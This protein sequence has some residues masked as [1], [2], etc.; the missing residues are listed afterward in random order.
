MA[1]IKKE[2]LSFVKGAVRLDE[3]MSPH[4]AFKIGGPAEAWVSP[5]DE[6]DLLNVLRYAGE[7][8]IDTFIIGGGSKLLV[9]DKGIRGI[10]LSLEAPAFGALVFEDQALTAGC[11]IKTRELMKKAAEKDLGGLE[12]LAGIPGT[13]GGAL[14]MNAGWPTKAI[15]DLVEEVTAVKDLKKIKL[16][17]SDLKFSYR[18][19]NLKGIVLLSARLRLEKKAKDEAEAEINKNFEKKRKTQDLG[20]PSAGSVFLNPSGTSPAWELIEKS[21]FKGKARGNAVVSVKHANFIVN[22]GNA[23]AADVKRLMD[24]IQKKVFKDSEIMLKLEVKLIG[25]F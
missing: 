21:G 6:D 1:K 9:G 20:F 23:K 14:I 3:P 25:E 18:D 24:E 13:L 15:G 2:D 4:T 19:S 12:F 11:G 10:V 8:N 17:K 22:R 5:S 7:N 16:G